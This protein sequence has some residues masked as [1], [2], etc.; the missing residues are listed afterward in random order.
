[1]TVV[2]F[3]FPLLLGRQ[4]SPKNHSTCTRR[5]V[6]PL[7]AIG[8]L[9][10]GVCWEWVDNSRP[11]LL[12]SWVFHKVT[13]P[14]ATSELSSSDIVTRG[15]FC[16]N[17]LNYPTV[18]STIWLYKKSCTSSYQQAVSTFAEHPPNLVRHAF[19]TLEDHSNS[20]QTPSFF[21]ESYHPL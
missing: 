14:R 9:L 19:L 1:M 15:S 2:S 17:C 6:P 16:H 10:R 11:S 3:S 12:Q 20:W 5:V 8:R 18:L 21:F 7:M 4:G 13:S